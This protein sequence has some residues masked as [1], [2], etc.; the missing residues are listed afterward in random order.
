M[1]S[2]G[3][4]LD[5]TIALVLV[6]G[7]LLLIFAAKKRQQLQEEHKIERIKLA[8]I[9]AKHSFEQETNHFSDQL[10]RGRS[11]IGTLDH[12]PEDQVPFGEHF[13]PLLYS[14]SLIQ[15]VRVA[16]E[17]GCQLVISGNE[18]QYSSCQNFEGHDIPSACYRWHDHQMVEVVDSTEIGKIPDSRGSTW[19]NSALNYAG[20]TCWTFDSKHAVL[21]ASA[22]KPA[23][24]S[25]DQMAV[26]AMEIDVARLVSTIR[27]VPSRIE[28]I[29]AMRFADGTIIYPAEG[30][31]NEEL[32]AICEKA[33]ALYDKDV[34]TRIFELEKDELFYKTMVHDVSIRGL[35]ANI[36]TIVPQE[37]GSFVNAINGVIIA[38]FALIMT[39]GTLLFLGWYKSQVDGRKIKVHEQRSKTQQ[40]VLQ[41]AIG[42]RE[43]LDREVHHR[44]KNNLQII[45]SL[46]NMQLMK[47]P[48]ELPLTETFRSNKNRIESIGI[49]HTALYNSKDLRGIDLQDFLSAIARWITSEFSPEGINVSYDVKAGGIQTDM[50]TARDIGMIV[51]ELMINS[52]Q[53]A[54]PHATGGH[55]DVA[56]AFEKRDQYRLSVHDNGI[57]MGAALLNR[58]QTTKMGLDIVD[59]LVEGLE[60]TFAY[61]S[62]NGVRCDALISI[63]SREPTDKPL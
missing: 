13:V 9:A 27:T 38:A 33:V 62:D 22:H 59:S 48:A 57:G 32:I 5:I 19:F 12:L 63:A 26:L 24:D 6:L 14:N 47:L 28:G 10:Q 20:Q 11:W 21:V 61:H 56:L 45:S 29:S 36:I 31:D 17:D 3:R 40:K 60:G 15:S 4:F 1:R 46:L 37:E 2:L 44:V 16:H 58:E 30:V 7:L 8:S 35:E 49:L 42:E 55:I 43:V 39:L 23:V 52:C 34:Y 41:Q 18:G 54:F 53:H 50:D 51:S 25:T